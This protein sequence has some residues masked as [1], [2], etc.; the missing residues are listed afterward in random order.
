MQSRLP[1]LGNM[2]MCWRASLAAS[3]AFVSRLSEFMAKGVQRVILMWRTRTLSVR[4]GWGPAQ[5]FMGVSA[6]RIWIGPRFRCALAQQCTRCYLLHKERQD[7]APDWPRANEL[8]C[9]QIARAKKSKNEGGAGGPVPCQ[10]SRATWPFP[11]W[12]VNK[13]K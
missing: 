10:V 3:R 2:E 13:N 7:C 8:P 11:T 5:I 9:V 1:R 6:A 4:S 12:P